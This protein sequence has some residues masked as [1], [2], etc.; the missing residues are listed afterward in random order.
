MTTGDQ[1]IELLYTPLSSLWH[2]AS[3]PASPRLAA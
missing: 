1:I 3:V 2:I